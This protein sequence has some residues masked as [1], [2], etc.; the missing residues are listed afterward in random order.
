MAMAMLLFHMC[1]FVVSSIEAMHHRFNFAQIPFPII[2][3]RPSVCLPFVLIEIVFDSQT[4]A[5]HWLAVYILR[6]FGIVL[7]ISEFD[8]VNTEHWTQTQIPM[9]NELTVLVYHYYADL[10]HRIVARARNVLWV[11]KW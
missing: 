11:E 7:H 8:T 2:I 3:F 9:G 1:E 6:A 5:L 4:S 10:S